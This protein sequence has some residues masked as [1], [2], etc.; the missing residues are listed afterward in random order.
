M[1]KTIQMALEA[2]GLLELQWQETEREPTEIMD[3]EM[4]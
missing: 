1:F 3:L 2:T 4:I